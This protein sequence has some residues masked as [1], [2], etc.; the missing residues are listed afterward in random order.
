MIVDFPISDSKPLRCGVFSGDQIIVRNSRQEV[1]LTIN[2]PFADQPDLTQ[3]DKELIGS[4]G[5]PYAV[6]TESQTGN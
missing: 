3:G 2:I 4:F 5:F 6:I 1:C